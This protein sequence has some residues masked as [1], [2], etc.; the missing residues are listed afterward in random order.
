VKP[1]LVFAF[2]VIPSL[3]S[4]QVTKTIHGD[5]TFLLTKGN[6]AWGAAHGAAEVLRIGGA[7]TPETTFGEPSAIATLPSGGV[8]LLDRKALDGPVIRMFDAQGKFVRN[9]GRLGSG[10]GEYKEY[11]DIKVSADGRLWVADPGNARL[12]VFDAAG[13]HQFEFRIPGNIWSIDMLRLGARHD[14]Y[15]M[16]VLPRQKDAAPSSRGYI[17]IDTT[18]RVLDTVRYV[19][20]VSTD[21]T[22]ALGGVILSDGRLLST[23]G[24]QL[25]FV[26]SSGKAGEPVVVSALDLPLVSYSTRER[27]TRDSLRKA[28]A[29][30]GSAGG[31]SNGERSI[32][33]IPPELPEHK[34][35]FSFVVTDGEERLWLVR[36]MLDTFPRVGPGKGWPLVM[37]VFRADGA[38]QGEVWFPPETQPYAMSIW[39]NSAWAIVTGADDDVYLVK[40]RIK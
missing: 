39:G 13:K 29:A 16:A 6:G 11:V 1:S 10:P 12:T 4:A 34:P 24:T 15:I 8:V 23:S 28:R 25:R 21:A 3:L 31:A 17:H 27:Q 36:S 18:G 5:T 26:M 7:K 35:P 20:N 2:L 9:V 40:Y 33:A 30:A 38:F 22:G 37:A 32:M 14:V 19:P